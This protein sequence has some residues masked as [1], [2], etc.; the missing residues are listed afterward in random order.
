MTATKEQVVGAVVEDM[1]SKP[2]VPLDVKENAD[3]AASWMQDGARD[4]KRNQAQRKAMRQ[5]EQRTRELAA[6]TAV[7]IR[8]DHAD[9]MGLAIRRIGELSGALSALATEL[10]GTTVGG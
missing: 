4:R 10:Y 2:G 7:G 6:W 3:E 9:D 1:L 8:C 5:I